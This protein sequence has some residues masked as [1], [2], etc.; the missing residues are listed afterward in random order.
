MNRK[1]LKA[2]GVIVAEASILPSQVFWDHNRKQQ[3]C[4]FWDV[5]DAVADLLGD[6]RLP[7]ERIPTAKQLHRQF[8]KLN[9]LADIPLAVIETWTPEQ[10]AA[11]E[12][13]SWDWDTWTSDVVT[14]WELKPAPDVLQPYVEQPFGTR[15]V[16]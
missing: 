13:W 6:L 15:G 16:R 5:L 3:G 8:Q 1:K 7:P 10:R 2:I 9:D 11:A 12:A 4:R 14:S